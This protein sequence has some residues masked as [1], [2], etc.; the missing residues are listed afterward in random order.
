MK[1]PVFNLFLLL[2][3]ILIFIAGLCIVLIL[4]PGVSFFDVSYVRATNSKYEMSY[5]VTEVDKYENIV[6]YGKSTPITVEFVQK[7][8]AVVTFN[9]NFSG[10]SRSGEEGPQLFVTENNRTLSITVNEYEPFG[11]GREYHDNTGLHIEVPI[12]YSGN[13]GIT[14]N[15]SPINF[16][17]LFGEINNISLTTQG[18]ITFSDK[19][20]FGNV[21][22]STDNRDIVIGEDISINGNLLVVT[23]RADL[24]VAN[25][26]GGS[27]SFTSTYGIVNFAGSFG[28]ATI[29]TKYGEVFGY[30]DSCIIGGKAVITA[31]GKVNLTQVDG[32]ANIHTNSGDVII[33]KNDISPVGGS[34]MVTTNSGDINLHG[35]FYAEQVSVKTNSGD[36]YAYHVGTLVVTSKYGHIDVTSVDVAEIAGGSGRVKVDHVTVSI[37]AT[38]KKGDIVLSYIDGLSIAEA[39]LE[40]TN[41]KIFVYNPS[42]CTYNITTKKGDVFFYGNAN[43]PS[44]V[45][46]TSKSGDVVATKISGRTIIKTN[47]KVNATVFS[48]SAKISIVGRDKNVTVDL[49]GEFEV[50]FDLS[51]KKKN[52]VAP[53]VTTKT[54]EY[55]TTTPGT[56]NKTIEIDT[57]WGQITVNRVEK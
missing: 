19:L 21:E 33:G 10:F 3:C 7:Q 8:N 1:K 50:F 35:S 31:G 6:V 13:I 14:A 17:G 18:K 56:E 41:G 23:N 51:S 48:P 57:R 37:V 52:I 26:V 34:L 55:I 12:Y 46:I 30:K 16:C 22:I 24:S 45:N 38:T 53:G 5:S 36:L 49:L 42:T 39:K 44:V 54:N 4:A 40:T 32:N 29:E 25:R 15:N 43:S 2:G 47:G 9:Q 11:Y 27:F 20:G 28:D